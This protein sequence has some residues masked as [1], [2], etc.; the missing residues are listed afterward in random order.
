MAYAP[1]TAIIPAA[2]RGMRLRP[3]TAAVHKE[4]F[5]VGSYP[6]IEWV[7]AEAVRSGCETIIVV[8]NPA[9]SII[10]NYLQSRLKVLRKKFSLEFASHTK[11]RG[12]AQAILIAGK[13]IHEPSFAVLLPD[14][15]IDSDVPV[16]LQ[17]GE[18]F[19]KDTTH[20][21]A[22]MRAQNVTATRKGTLKLTIHS[23]S[24]FKITGTIQ[25][26]EPESNASTSPLLGVGRSIMTRDFIEHARKLYKDEFEGELTDGMVLQAMIDAGLDL[27]A[28]RIEGHCHDISTADGHATAI[29]RFGKEKPQWQ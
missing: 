13:L 21:A 26:G 11:S 29:R 8:I 18:Y 16:L 4:M 22:V 3:V 2:G 20:I 27:Y 1:K 6:A 15:L 19:D 9:K 14:N 10:K 28:C 25:S 7:I 12:L 5:P 23:E 17:L 24:L